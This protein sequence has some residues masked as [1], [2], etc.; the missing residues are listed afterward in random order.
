MSRI[1]V[2]GLG[3]VSSAG[4]GVPA[5]LD[6][7]ANNRPPE[8]SELERTTG[9]G[10]VVRTSVARVPA[11]DDRSRLPRDQRLRRASAVGKFGAAAAFEALGSERFEASRTGDLRLGVV[12]TMMNGCVNYSNRF[13][14][15]VL[16]DPGTASPILFPETVYNAPSSHLSA[17]TRSSAPN[18]TLVGDGAEFFTGLELAAEWLER[19]DCD[20]CL[21]VAPEE[22]DWL[23]A[24]A[25]GYYS[26]RMLPSEGAAALL[27]EKGGSGP[28]LLA[29]PDPVNYAEEADRLAG[30]ARVWQDLDVSDNG[31]TLWSDGRTGVARFDRAESSVE[32]NGPRLS[33]RRLLGEAL[34]AAAGLQTV[35]ALGV[36]ERE[37]FERAVVTAVGGNE[38]LGGA[39]FG[40]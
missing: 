11:L 30:F 1:T 33:V 32:W 2:S 23:S 17:V 18:D 13:Y 27:L 31:H 28:C 21:V 5:L 26:H 7:I 4:W 8:I 35:A 3:A 34:G 9:E 40:R 39:V 12:C 16:R 24:E 19:G 38:G 29:V 36:L 6:A 14:G 37:G 15:E 10:V 20:A 22:T 25:M